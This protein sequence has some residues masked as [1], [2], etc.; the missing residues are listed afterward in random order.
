MTAP[1][2]LALGWPLT[3]WSPLHCNEFV[4]QKTLRVRENLSRTP[5]VLA[6]AFFSFKE[7]K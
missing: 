4:A 3:H 1:R 7:V 5:A 6:S 2:V